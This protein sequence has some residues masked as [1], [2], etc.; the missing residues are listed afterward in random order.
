LVIG[1]FE[2]NSRVLH[3]RIKM[4]TTFDSTEYVPVLRWKSSEREGL[5]K[6]DPTLRNRITPLFEFV[7]QEF[8]KGGS[9]SNLKTHAHEIGQSWGWNRLF[10]VDFHLLGETR[11]IH[12]VPVFLGLAKGYNLQPGLVTGLDR[13]ES[14]QK[15]IKSTVGKT[16]CELALRISAYD[17]RRAGFLQSLEKALKFFDKKPNGLHLLIDFQSISHPLPQ[18]AIF[19]AGIPVLD[20][21]RSLTVIAGAFPKDLSHLKKNNEYNLP[22]NDWLMWKNFAASTN[23]RIPSFGDYTIQYGIFEEHEGQSFNFS[24]SLRYTTDNYWVIMRGEG[25][26]N[27]N[28]AGYAQFPAQAQLLTERNEF[29]GKDF[30]DGDLYI[31]T[32][33]QQFSKTGQMKQW[34]AA[35]FNHHITFTSRQVL[36]FA[37]NVSSGIPSFELNPDQQTVQV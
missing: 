26:H 15:V 24:A 33:A 11:G 3:G 23:G 34:L 31:H 28:G 25:V 20:E 17:L 21:W 30:S 19:M 1:K 9:E 13:S 8:E 10:F 37:A 36:Q 16:G 5:C 27:E 35:T 6:L 29:C 22:R 7:P 2:N 4:K 32:M 12:F 14:Y 18:L